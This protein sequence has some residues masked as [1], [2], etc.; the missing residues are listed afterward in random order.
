MRC[1]KS[2]C[3]I[4][5]YFLPRRAVPSKMESQSEGNVPNNNPLPPEKKKRTKRGQRLP[6]WG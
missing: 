2:F 1:L 6:T 3:L 5:V 4:I